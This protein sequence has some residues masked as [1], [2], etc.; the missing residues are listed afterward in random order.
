MRFFYG[1]F[2]FICDSCNLK[3]VCLFAES[4]HKPLDYYINITLGSFDF[5]VNLSV[6]F[7]VGNPVL[8]EFTLNFVL[9]S[10]SE[11][12]LRQEQENTG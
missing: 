8:S 2:S 7:V 6:S 10:V 11:P 12:C 5:P 3:L 9:V 4:L 1:L